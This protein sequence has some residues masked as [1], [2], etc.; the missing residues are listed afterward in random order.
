M[1]ET[2]DWLSIN[3]V[4]ESRATEI[5]REISK[6]KVVEKVIRS[7]R[8]GKYYRQGYN[9]VWILL[10]YSEHQNG[11]RKIFRIDRGSEIC[12][13]DR[14]Q[15]NGPRST[16]WLGVS[17][18]NMVSTVQ[19]AECL[20]KLEV[21]PFM[22]PDIWEEWWRSECVLAILKDM[23]STRCR[24]A[25]VRSR[26]SVP[27][28]IKWKCCQELVQAHGFRSVKVMLDTPPGSPK[29][30][31]GAK[32]GYVRVQICPSRPVRFFMVKP[33]IECLVRIW[34]FSL[35]LGS[36]L[37][38][39]CVLTLSPKSGLDTGFGLVCIWFPLLEART[40]QDAK[41][42]LLT[43]EYLLDG[44]VAD[45]QIVLD[46]VASSWEYV[47]QGKHEVLQYMK[48]VHA[49]R[50]VEHEVDR[51][52]TRCCDACDQAMQTD[53]WRTW[54]LLTWSLAIHPDREISSSG[55]QFKT[56]LDVGLLEKVEKGFGSQKS[57]SRYL[58]VGSW[59]EA[60]GLGYRSD[61]EDG[62]GISEMF[63]HDR[64]L[65]QRTRSFPVYGNRTRVRDD[66]FA[67]IG[68]SHN[69]DRRHQHDQSAQSNPRPDQNR[70]RPQEQ[71]TENT[72][73]LLHDA[74]RKT[75]PHSGGHTNFSQGERLNFNKG[76]KSNKGKG[77]GF[78]GQANNRGNTGVCCTCDQSGHISRFCPKNQRN[79]QRSNQQG[80]S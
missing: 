77:R 11:S 16:S 40:W 50:P 69:W 31:P 7:R 36:R 64:S 12:S 51:P 29:K 14:N 44:R 62:N 10:K 61:Q 27:L 38:L 30:C 48:P 39:C 65:L 25:C 13:K 9:G 74:E 55:D 49:S 63:G 59:H 43:V 47:C 5:D 46:V 75:I 66:S 71:G 18:Q 67:S 21:S 28:M 68:P 78:G 72:L 60:R 2:E 32:G 54:C 52:T 58:E 41:S 37:S 23:W 80:Y 34:N 76:Q 8:L 56:S 6:N 1:V 4:V 35:G 22:Q 57:G 73:K 3:L 53:M 70:A 79:N 19:Q 26:Q 42:N 33:R 17:V 15:T 24:R 45:D 20:Q